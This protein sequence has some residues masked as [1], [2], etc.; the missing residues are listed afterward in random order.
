M[1]EKIR[2]G[3]NFPLRPRVLSVSMQIT[4]H[5]HV[6]M[7]LVVMQ[8]RNASFLAEPVEMDRSREGGRYGCNPTQGR[9]ALA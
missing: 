8:R 4:T 1:Q 9:S 2:G 3:L 6:P 5:S 7:A